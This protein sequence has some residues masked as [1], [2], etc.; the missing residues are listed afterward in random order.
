MRKIFFGLLV[1][2][3]TNVYS[4]YSIN[5]IVQ[6]SDT[7]LPVIGATIQLQKPEKAAITDV[8]GEF[9]FDNLSQGSYTLLVAS[10][11]YGTKT[12]KVEVPRESQIQILLSPT[13]IEIEEVIVSTPFHQL[14]S[15]NVMKVERVTME[16]LKR[17][18]GTTLTDGLSQIAG[19][20]TITT[21]AGIGKPVI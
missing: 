3:V 15:E 4:Q 19:V 12:L 1:L 5:G 2:A 21:G 7:N 13:A 11:G 10:L 9:S 14:Q 18:G 8:S 6:D 20:E 17:T 16:N